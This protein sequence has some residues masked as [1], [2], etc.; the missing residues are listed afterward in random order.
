M[1][2]RGLH[3]DDRQKA[4]IAAALADGAT[5]N[6]VSKALGHQ[7]RT[8]KA[9]RDGALALGAASIGRRR[10]A[11]EPRPEPLRP[12]Q[13]AARRAQS[14]RDEIIRMVAASR[15]PLVNADSIVVEPHVRRRYDPRGDAYVDVAA[16]PRT[17]LSDTLKVAP[18]DDPRGRTFLFTGAQ[19]DTAV[20]PAFWANLCAYA[21]A[22]GAKI[23]VG[24]WT[25]ETHWWGENNPLSRAYDPALTDHLCFGQLA[26]G[27]RFVFCGEMNTLPTAAR[28]IG[29]LVTYSRGRWAVF[30]HGK[31][32]LKSVA[33]TD[34]DVQ[35]HQVMTTGAVTLPKVIPR[36]AGVKSIFHHVLGATLVEF[37]AAGDLFCRQ[38]IATDDGAFY[39]LD[40]HVAGGRV[41]NGH[42]VRSVVA[43]DI[44]VR[45]L[46]PANAAATFGFTE[47]GAGVHYVDNLVDVL[48]PEFVF[49]HDVFDNEA[50][51]HHHVGDSG[52]GFEMA[53][54]GRDRV[55]AEVE[56]AAEF[57]AAVARAGQ[58]TVVV[59]SNHDLG[60]ERYVRE[61][62]YR[63]DG[64]NSRTG[65]QL[66]EA[67]MAF[68]ERA[69]RAMDRGEPVPT[70]SLFEHAARQA[71]GDDLAG[72]EWVHDGQSFPVDGIEH[73]H[74]GFRGV[75]GAKAS[76]EGFAR[77]GRKMSVAD[78]HAPEILE[79]VYRAGVMAL[80]HGYN[81]GPSSWAVAHL[82][83]YQNGK[84]SVVTLQRGK[85]R[86]D[87]PRVRVR[88]AAA[89]AE[90]T[91]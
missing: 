51:N 86:A 62:R 48:R 65:L 73:G 18:I 91:A 2:R 67:Y 38:I 36:K 80:R 52:Y 4:V 30:P 44:H 3:I 6:A 63:N 46:D 50:R 25:Y 78:G 47:A 69:A 55:A 31:V 43:G 34:P 75:N 61:G 82:V 68:R 40:R 27:D 26:I 14:L 81:K 79:G 56:E 19:N 59:E 28:P 16:A 89:A 7:W 87:R 29:D 60:L 66:E 42:R 5:V 24:P 11:P 12:E 9:V 72:V 1:G 76:V 85:W 37:D 35:A 90:R 21:A 15:W 45:K 10:P 57:L 32:Q 8:V 88:S 22:L 70:F 23:V 20:H 77:I 13:H 83:Q 71:L 33:S 49:L 39:D 74:H 54:R 17:W 58:R 84:R 41:T 64:L 53:V